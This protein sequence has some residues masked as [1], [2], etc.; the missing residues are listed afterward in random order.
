MVVYFTVIFLIQP[1]KTDEITNKLKTCRDLSRRTPCALQL[2]KPLQCPS[3]VQASFSHRNFP[4]QIYLTPLYKTGQK[5]KEHC[6]TIFYRR[7]FKK[8]FIYCLHTPVK[9]FLGFCFSLSFYINNFSMSSCP[10]IYFSNFSNYTPS[11]HLRR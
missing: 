9:L 1:R 8:I 2:C 4:R 7:K 11:S 3:N 5:I 10:G 6:H